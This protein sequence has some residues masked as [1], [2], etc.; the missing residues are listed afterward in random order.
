MIAIYIFLV[1]IQIYRFCPIFCHNT[2]STEGNLAEY[3]YLCGKLQLVTK[4]MHVKP[5]S[6][7][8]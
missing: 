1:Q 6:H 4:I 7:E 5:T 8:M 3:D 2:L